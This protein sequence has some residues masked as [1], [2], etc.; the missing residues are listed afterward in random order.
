MGKIQKYTV[1]YRYTCEV[2]GE[3]TAWLEYTNQVETGMAILPG[4]MNGLLALGDVALMRNR[5][6]KQIEE[7]NFQFGFSAGANC[8]K[9]G[10]RQSWYKKDPRDWLCFQRCLNCAWIYALGLIL[11]LIPA[12]MEC[13]VAVIILPVVGLLFGIWRAVRSVRKSKQETAACVAE[14]N[15]FQEECASRS[16][17][18]IP[19]LTW[20][21]KRLRWVITK[22]RAQATAAQYIEHSKSCCGDGRKTNSLNE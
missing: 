15:A 10:A 16:A 4:T 20:A 11:S 14:E 1:D 8:P 12:F 21:A 13:F 5:L 3:Q 2:C 7:E 17:H 9:C 19:S 18:N 22:A 6:K